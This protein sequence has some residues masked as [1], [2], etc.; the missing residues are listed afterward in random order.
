LHYSELSFLISAFDN[1]DIPVDV[2]RAL[3][4][5]DGTLLNALGAYYYDEEIIKKLDVENAKI[6][7]GKVGAA[8]VYDSASLG[9]IVSSN[10][11][12][13]QDTLDRMKNYVPKNRDTQITTEESFMAGVSKAK[14]VVA[15]KISKLPAWLES[16]TYQYM[17]TDYLAAVQEMNEHPD[18]NYS[19]VNSG[20]V[21]VTMSDIFNTGMR[22]L[23]KQLGMAITKGTTED[24]MEKFDEI[25]WY[26]KK[27]GHFAEVTDKNQAADM[28]EKLAKDAESFKLGDKYQRLL[29][30]YTPEE[31]LND[32]IPE[33]IAKYL[34]A[35][36]RDTALSARANRQEIAN[37]GGQVAGFI[38]Q[39]DQSA[40]KMG[41]ADVRSFI[42]DAVERE[43]KR[44]ISIEVDKDALG[45]GRAAV[46]NVYFDLGNGKRVHVLKQLNTGVQQDRH[47]IAGDDVWQA[48]LEA[49]KPVK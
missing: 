9:T 23:Q 34:A 31:M 14:T 17:V 1:A 48:F 22:A 20:G 49:F 39:I 42:A 44:S 19:R 13:V 33:Q 3:A 25:S 2:V 7:A 32:I 41:L 36:A 30:I 35:N 29:S 38:A 45:E 37:H 10:V 4:N 21:V 12:R 43:E 47:I 15:D 5:D 16:T 40:A 27:Y 18:K 24:V 28:R 26:L 11:M 6:K 8:V 46:T